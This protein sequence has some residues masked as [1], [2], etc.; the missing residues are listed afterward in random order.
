MIDGFLLGVI[1]IA[2]I[3]SGV[4]FLKFWKSTRDSFFL[5]FGASFIIEGLNRAALLFF[6]HPNEANAITYLV[7]LF[8]F[9]LIL[10]AI[11]RKNYGKNS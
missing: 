5:A 10:F 4:F 6:E 2:S 8:S 9:L 3:T 1:S 11:V 7:R